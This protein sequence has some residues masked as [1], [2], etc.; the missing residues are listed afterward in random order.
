MPFRNTP[1]PGGFGPSP[2]FG[3]AHPGLTLVPAQSHPR[4]AGYDG[5]SAG[6]HLLGWAA[7]I[8]VAALAVAVTFAIRRR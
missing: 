4:P 1:G 7:L 2:E 5:S 8:L 6:A 3:S